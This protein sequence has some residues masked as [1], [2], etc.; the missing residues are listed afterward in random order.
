LA[1]NDCFGVSK[2]GNAKEEKNWKGLCVKRERKEVGV[3]FRVRPKDGRCKK[4]ATP[5]AGL[6][7]AI[8][9]R[10]HSR[11]LFYSRDR[12][13]P[14]LYTQLARLLKSSS[15][16]LVPVCL[17]LPTAVF[18]LGKVPLKARFERA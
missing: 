7:G 9:F 3:R 8:S 17:F 13:V 5:R 14:L 12:V 18:V 10:E 11:S 2:E 1:E 15:R 16:V 6:L 4:S